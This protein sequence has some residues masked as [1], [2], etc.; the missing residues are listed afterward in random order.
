MPCVVANFASLP[1]FAHPHEV[2]SPLRKSYPGWIV[3][4]PQE[5]AHNHL[6]C[7]VAGTRDRTLSWPNTRPVMSMIFGICDILS[8]STICVKDNL[9][10]GDGDGLR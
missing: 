2:M 9:S 7:P 3:L 4:L 10:K 5:H 1:F 6:A 8:R